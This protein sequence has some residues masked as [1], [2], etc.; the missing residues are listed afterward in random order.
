MLIRLI[1]QLDDNQPHV[2]VEIGCLWHAN[3][4]GLSLDDQSESE[5]TTSSYKLS[6]RAINLYY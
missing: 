2:W 6:N 4:N 1:T 5:N 3:Q